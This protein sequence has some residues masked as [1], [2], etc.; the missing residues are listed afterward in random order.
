MQNVNII[1]YDNEHQ[2]HIRAIREAVFM[3]EQGVSPELEFD[4]LDASAMQVLVAVDGKYVG[5]GR[6]LDDGHIGRIA[7]L[8]DYRGLGLGGRVVQALVDEAARRGYPRVYL[9]AQTH[10]VD[11]YTKLG[12]TPYGDEFMDAGIPHLAMEKS[13]V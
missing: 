13:L 9:G 10:A 11:F 7:I 8:R 4:G 2:P 5:T 1:A 12:F 3:Q 6:M